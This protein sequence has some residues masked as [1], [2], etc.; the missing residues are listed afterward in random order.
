MMLALRRIQDP[1]GPDDGCRVL[2]DR[3][4]PRGLSKEHAGLG[5]WLRDIAPSTELR[6]WFGHDPARWPEFKHR[7]WAELRAEP[8]AGAVARLRSLAAREQVTLLYAARDET[9]NNARALL[10]FLEA[11]GNPPTLGSGSEPGATVGIK[12]RAGRVMGR[13]HGLR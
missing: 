13:S 12:P 6:R 9:Y 2:V 10:E 1:A 3:L 11:G 8:A 5:E 4:W 7:Y